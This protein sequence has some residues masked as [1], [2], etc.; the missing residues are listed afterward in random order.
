MLIL[1]LVLTYTLLPID[2][3]T[4]LFNLNKFE[5]C[6]RDQSF[7]ITALLN[8]WIFIQGI[9]SMKVYSFKLLVGYFYSSFWYVI[10]LPQ[11]SVLSLYRHTYREQISSNIGKS[12]Y[13]NN[14]S[15][16]IYECWNLAFCKQSIY[17]S[18]IQQWEVENGKRKMDRAEISKLTY[19]T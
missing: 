10:D 3:R 7:F 4:H 2:I 1:R 12:K 18:V 15:Q 8:L 6:L 19:N 16:V 11:L 17:I 9:S 14:N 5:F 13:L